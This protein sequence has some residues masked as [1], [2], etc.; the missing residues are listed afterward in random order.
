M[1]SP[2][3]L[4]GVHCPH[5]STTRNRETPWATAT[6]SASPSITMKPAEPRPPPASARPSQVSGASRA[7]AGRSGLAVPDRPATTSLRD[8]AAEALEDLAQRGAE[9][10][11]ADAGARRAA[12]DRADHR[13]G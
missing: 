6:R 12:A 10:E 4:Q 7:V 8:A 13:P 1:A 11:L 3:S 5:D 9:L 2:S